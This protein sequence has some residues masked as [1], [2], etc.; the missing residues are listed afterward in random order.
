MK[1]GDKVRCINAWSAST[2]DRGRIYT[3]LEVRQN[4]QYLLTEGG[5]WHKDRFEPVRSTAAS[6]TNG[7]A[8]EADRP[9][10]YWDEERGC[11]VLD[12]KY[13]VQPPP[14][15]K[16]NEPSAEA[17]ET[18]TT[19]VAR[20]SLDRVA[21]A[22]QKLMDERDFA[23]SLLA[24]SE[25]NGLSWKHRAEAA[26]KE[27]DHWVGYWEA[28]H[29]ICSRRAAVAEKERDREK[30][31]AAK[32]V[33]AYTTEM[34]RRE[35]AEARRDAYKALYAGVDAQHSAE[36]ARAEAAEKDRDY[37]KKNH[38]GKDN[39]WKARHDE[40]NASKAQLIREVREWYDGD[41]DGLL[42]LLTRHEQGTAEHP[43]TGR[44][45]ELVRKCRDHFEDCPDMANFCEG[46]D[47]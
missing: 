4:G 25:E 47:K 23:N 28:Q 20:G 18:A 8:P 30:E 24:E 13:G 29:A 22:L 1:P 12:K 35:S 27:R 6:V 11:W 41:S 39:Y 26:E 3:V 32:W 33:D 38:L 46:F 21:F 36:I 14:A 16:N 19:L 34:R 44:L 45:R 15:F 17:R 37:W 43:D 10:Q 2:L 9:G 7:Q 5:E 42:E 31:N 40:A